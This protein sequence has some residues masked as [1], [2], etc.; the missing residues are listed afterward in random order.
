[1]K[2]K[3]KEW[4]EKRKEDMKQF[5]QNH[6]FEFG[7]V[8]AMFTIAAGGE[9]LSRTAFKCD[10][11]DIGIGHG[12]DTDDR[13]IAICFEEINKRGRKAYERSTMMRLDDA[14]KMVTLLQNN[15]EERRKILNQE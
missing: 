4:F 8:A 14:E 10:H 15:I 7:Y 9:V 5:Y 2:Q 13:D 11:V 1:M 3:T 12:R 6:K